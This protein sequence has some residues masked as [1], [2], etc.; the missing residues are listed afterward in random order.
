MLWLH[1]GVRM[2]IIL[3]YQLLMGKDHIY[4]VS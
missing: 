4:E 2:T 1:I 3:L